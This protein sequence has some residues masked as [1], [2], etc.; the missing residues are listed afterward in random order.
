MGC[1]RIPAGSSAPTGATRCGPNSSRWPTAIKPNPSCPASRASAR[2][3]ATRSTPAGGTTATPARTWRTWPASASASSAPGP[4]RSSACRTWPRRPSSS[5]SSSARRRRWTCEPIGPRTRSGPTHYSRAGSAS[6]YR[7]FRSSRP[8]GR[9]TR[10]WSPMPGRASP[11]SFR[12]C[13]TTEMTPLVDPAQRTR[14]IEIADFAKMEEIR[15]RVDEIVTDPATAEALKPWY[16]YFCKRP[17]FHDEYLQTFNRDNV[18]LVDT[19]G[20]GVE[21]ITESGVVVDGVVYELDCL[22]FATGFEVGTDYC[23]RT[24]FELIGRDGVT[25]TDQW[26]DGVRTFQGLCQRLPELLHRK[27]L[28]G[29][30]D[31]ELPVSA[32]RAGDPRRV[33]HRVGTRAG[34]HRSR[35]VSRRRSRLGRHGRRPLDR[36]APSEPRRAPPATTTGRERRTPRLGRAASFSVR[37]PSTPTS[38]RRGGPKGTW[39]GST[40]A[41]RRPA[42]DKP[43]SPA[44]LRRRPGAGGDPASAPTE[45][46]DHR[47]GLRRAWRGG[48]VAPG[49]HRRSGHH[50]GRRRRR[51]HVAAQH[52]SRRRVRH[53]ESPVLVFVR[54]QQILEPHLCAP[55]RDPGLPGVGGRRLRSASP[56]HARY[57]G[58]R[59]PL[60]RGHAVGIGTA[61]GE[62]DAAT[63]DRRRRRVRRRAVRFAKAA[64]HRRA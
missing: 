30:A 59:V 40:F 27:H 14:D 31:G 34:R 38:W 56:P 44:A 63:A 1:K 11:A 36:D 37:P 43:A 24:G 49:R 35:G 54:A 9:P 23:R 41:V 17:C 45:G 61:A 13:A 51:G 39:K 46:G 55:A 4:P 53:P 7:T 19:R 12:S 2:F 10:T 62:R 48:G 33:D 29:G 26:R 58:A 16:G 50:R 32:G 42:S 5:T 15:A 52:L 3:A 28:A 25:L 64:R 22:I 8:A 60:E 47:C 18:T 57:Q 20:R 21:R 6:A